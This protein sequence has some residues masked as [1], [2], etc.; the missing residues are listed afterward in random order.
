MKLIL[1]ARLRERTVLKGVFRCPIIFIIAEAIKIFLSSEVVEVTTFPAEVYHMHELDEVRGQ[2]HH[3]ELIDAGLLA[4]IGKVPVLLPPELI[5]R[6]QNCIGRKIG[7]LRAS[8]H[9]YRLKF[10]DGGR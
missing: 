10:I 1:P 9:D 3:V 2:L 4:I 7:I 8:D 6:M 5:D